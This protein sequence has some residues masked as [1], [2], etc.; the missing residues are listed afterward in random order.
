MITVGQSDPREAGATALLQ[1]SHALMQSLFNP[2]DNHYL[3]IDALCADDVHFFTAR[4]GETVL[5][6][7]AIKVK[8][9]MAEVKSMF[10]AETARGRGIAD[11]I[12]RALEERA[13]A[14]RLTWMRLE[15]GDLLHAA[16][17]LYQRHGFVRCGVFGDYTE[18]AS[19]IFMEKRL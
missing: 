1:A 5:G 16:H 12:L 15:T 6:T 8:A 13:R 2:E 4:D 9:D 18:N 11:A 7:G 10:V 3:S 19:S 17:R 14:L